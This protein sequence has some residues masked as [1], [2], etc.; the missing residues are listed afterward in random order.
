MRQ[1]L[2]ALV[3]ALWWGSLSAI[4]FMTALGLITGAVPAFNAIRVNVI[5][6]FR[7]I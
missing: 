3:A 7:R 5:T 6:A 1:R 4:G 2:P